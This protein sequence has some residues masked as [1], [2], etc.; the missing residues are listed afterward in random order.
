MEISWQ[1]LL[2]AVLFTVAHCSVDSSNIR[3]ISSG[4]SF[5]FCR[6]YCQQSINI[7]FNPLQLIAMKQPNFPQAAYPLVQQQH[8][9]SSAQWQELI[10]VLNMQTFSALGDRI[11]CPDCADGGA[12]WIEIDSTNGVKRVTFE[13]GQSVKGIESLIEKLRQLRNQYA[14]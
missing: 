13:N 5:G 11:G 14:L 4:T 10:S 2:L 9:F 6:S 7:T 12:E 1:S 3:S 8:P